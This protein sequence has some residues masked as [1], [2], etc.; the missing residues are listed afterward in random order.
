MTH[1]KWAVLPVYGE[2]EER[3]GTHS[4]AHLQ[5]EV[6][7]YVEHMTGPHGE[8]LWWNEEGKLEGLRMNAGATQ[9]LRKHGRL[10]PGDYIA[11]NMVITAISEKRWEKLREEFPEGETVIIPNGLTIVRAS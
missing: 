5:R 10:F 11:G 8:D 6:G 4:L 1:P 7:G 3:P 9:Y 2:L